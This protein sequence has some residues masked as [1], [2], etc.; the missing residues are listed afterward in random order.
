[1][2]ALAL[3]QQPASPLNA[4]S[5]DRQSV[6]RLKILG[7][8]E[9]SLLHVKLPSPDQRSTRDLRTLALEQQRVPPWKTLSVPPTVDQQL[10]WHLTILALEAQS[11]FELEIEPIHE[12][13][14]Q[15]RVLGVAGERPRLSLA[16]DWNWPKEE[17]QARFLNS[18]LVVPSWHPMK[19]SFAVVD[20][21]AAP[22]AEPSTM[23]LFRLS[24]S[25]A[26]AQVPLSTVGA[27]PAH[28]LPKV[29]C[30]FPMCAQTSPAGH[31]RNHRSS[32]HSDNPRAND[33]TSPPGTAPPGS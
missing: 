17:A 32:H 28:L 7:V 14:A 2:K 21:P 15:E 33:R 3:Q 6:W 1:L 13:P 10:V 9:Q 20:L 22:Q 27:R 24:I 30:H 16:W 11:L 23:P 19:F 8:H 29:K 31:C 25:M 4:L 5:P 12:T 26:P 18:D